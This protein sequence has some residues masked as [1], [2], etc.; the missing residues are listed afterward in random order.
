[1]S[2]PSTYDAIRTV[3]ISK[4]RLNPSADKTR[5]SCCINQTYTAVA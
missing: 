1:V 5:A 3:V 2:L 4:L